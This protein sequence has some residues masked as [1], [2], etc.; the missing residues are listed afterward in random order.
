LKGSDSTGKYSCIL[1]SEIH[2]DFGSHL[3]FSHGMV[4]CRKDRKCKS[5]F[6]S[7]EARETHEVLKHAGSKSSWKTSC[8]NC[9]IK[10]FNQ[11]KLAVHRFTE[12]KIFTCSLC[13]TVTSAEN[14]F[15]SHLK[16]HSFNNNPL[17]DGFLSFISLPIATVSQDLSNIQCNL[18]PEQK[19]RVSTA[20]GGQLF[21]QHFQMEHNVA[22]S[23]DILLY[24]EMEQ[25]LS[26]TSDILLRLFNG[27]QIN[28]K[29]LDQSTLQSSPKRKSSCVDTNESKKVKIEQVFKHLTISSETE[30]EVITDI[31]DNVLIKSEDSMEWSASF[32]TSEDNESE[33]VENNFDWN[34]DFGSMDKEIG[35]TITSIKPF[36]IKQEKQEV[37]IK[38]ENQEVLI[39][40]EKQEA[41]INP[42][43]QE[44][45]EVTIKAEPTGNLTW[46][47]IIPLIGGSA[48]GCSQSAGNLPA[49]HLSYTP[50]SNNEAHLD[51]Y[52]PE[53]PK[54][55]LDK[56]PTMAFQGIDYVNSVCPCAGLSMLN[57]SRADDGGVARGSNNEHNKWMFDTSEYVLDKIKPKVFWGENAPGLFNDLGKGVVDGLIEVGKRHGY[58]FSIIKTNSEL[59]GLPQ[60][61][62]RTFYFFWNTPTVPKLNW[63]NRKAKSFVDFLNEIPKEATLQDM[64][65]NEGKASE[66]FRPYQ[67]VL[68]RE[69]LTHEQFYKKQKTGTISRYLEKNN[70]EEECI[71][72]LEE[73][74]PNEKMSQVRESGRTHV[75][76]IEHCMNK[77]SMGKGY[78]DDSPRFYDETFGTLMSKTMYTA[79]HPVEDRY[80]NV[81]EMMHLMGLPHDFEIDHPKNINHIAQNVPVNTAKDWADEVKLFCEGKLPLTDYSFLK[82]DNMAQTIVTG[83]KLGQQK[84]EKIPIPRKQNVKGPKMTTP[85]KQSEKVV[86]C[87]PTKTRGRPKKINESLKNI[88]FDKTI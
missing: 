52:W 66:R 36:V 87:E 68:E 25:N 20:K 6:E 42:N 80:L 16:S 9:G 78:W 2:E 75:Q 51:R 79:V 74:Y 58:S 71:E 5:Y 28:Y 45:N 27:Q 37:L 70:L 85:T 62:I 15:K 83:I 38:Q 14:F 33:E 29:N 12:H 84:I 34:E 61:R 21:L 76:Y 65:M 18:C 30:D 49:F 44:F 11:Y 56:D 81:R 17:M 39:K 35:S 40:Q 54:Y 60:K 82:Q 53:V 69:G 47:T 73:K 26:K 57:T 19:G 88:A 77:K 1:C 23:S 22:K 63:K 86:K 43:L 64:F 48:I 13:T 50:F 24:F 10:F 3:C 8:G 59:H 7:M 67:F 31:Q 55:H 72:W 46:A 41:H 32:I 4:K